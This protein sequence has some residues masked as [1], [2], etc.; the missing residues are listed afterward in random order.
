MSIDIQFKPKIARTLRLRSWRY[1]LKN[2]HDISDQ[3]EYERSG[4]AEA[5]W[6]LKV[7]VSIIA[8]TDADPADKNPM[9]DD[10]GWTVGFC[11]GFKISQITVL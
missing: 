11:S 8:V 6:L 4:I 2:D 3:S 9:L 10:R 5:A 1:Y 7:G